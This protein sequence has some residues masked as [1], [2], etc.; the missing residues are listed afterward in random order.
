VFRST[1]WGR[2]PILTKDTHRLH[3]N[4]WT[5]D[6]DVDNNGTYDPPVDLC[7]DFKRWVIPG[8]TDG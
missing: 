5:G 2:N 3:C 4:V 8:R 1:N 7:D 6:G